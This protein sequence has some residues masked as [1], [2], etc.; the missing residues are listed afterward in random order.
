MVENTT[1]HMSGN[2]IGVVCTT[3]VHVRKLLGGRYEA[4][5]GIAIMGRQNMDEEEY[6]ACNY[7]PFHPEFQDNIVLGF[8]LSEQD[9]LESLKLDMKN[10]VNSLWAI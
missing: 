8:G 6:K 10:T 1:V 3:D 5:C 4:R 7:D 2:I 9:A